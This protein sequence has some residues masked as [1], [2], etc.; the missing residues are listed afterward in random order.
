MTCLT[1]PVLMAL[2][3][4]LIAFLLLIIYYGIYVLAVPDGYFI[5]GQFLSLW[6]F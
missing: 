2:T 4:L 3:S 5:P 1:L 6:R